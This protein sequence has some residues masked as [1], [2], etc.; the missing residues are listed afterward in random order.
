[1]YPTRLY[2][3]FRELSALSCVTRFNR[4]FHGKSNIFYATQSQEPI[5][6][7]NF[8]QLQQ[9]FYGKNFNGLLGLW[10]SKLKE[11]RKIR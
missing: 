3:K 10:T 2:I 5:G 6:T 8:Q 1:M 7:N 4:D 11:K 9:V